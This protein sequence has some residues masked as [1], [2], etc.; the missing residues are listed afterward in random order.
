VSQFC[1]DLQQFYAYFKAGSGGSVCY[2]YVNL[3]SWP[4]TVVD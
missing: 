4:R 3:S 2:S 1:A